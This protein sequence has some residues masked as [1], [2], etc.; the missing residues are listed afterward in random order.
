MIRP[1]KLSDAAAIAA[2]Y[3]H[4]VLHTTVTF[5][6]EAVTPEEMRLRI[7]GFSASHPYLVVEEGGEVLAYAYAHLWRE[8]AAYCH[9]W[10]TTIYVKE[11]CRQ[12]GIGGELLEVLLAGCRKL[13]GV[14][15][16]IACITEENAASR[17]FHQ[18]HGYRQVSC[19]QEVG[20]KLG[21]WLGVVDMELRLE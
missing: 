7:A 11:G 20:Y 16:L 21:R 14:H 1:V 6:T 9:T 2:I 4:Y 8:R 5:E 19:F 3:N 13:G 18:K 17:A 12:K 15:A 10:E